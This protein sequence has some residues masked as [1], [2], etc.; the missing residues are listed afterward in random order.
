[1]REQSNNYDSSLTDDTITIQI[2]DTINR[3]VLGFKRYGLSMLLVLLSTTLT[4]VLLWTYSH[5]PVYEKQTIYTVTITG[6]TAQDNLAT[7]F[8]TG[9]FPEL[10]NSQLSDV[11]R[12]DL[13]LSDQDS[14][15]V[16]VEILNSVNMIRMYARSTDPEIAENVLNVLTARYPEF[17]SKDLG[18][19]TLTEIED[20]QHLNLVEDN[21]RFL[22]FALVG[23]IVGIVLNSLFLLRFI[24]R[25]KT[26]QST[27]SISRITNLKNYAVLPK[28]TQG[29]VERKKNY[30][31]QIILQDIFDQ[32]IKASTLKLKIQKDDTL[33]FVSAKPKEGVTTIVGEIAKHLTNIGQRPLI[34]QIVEDSSNKNMI[35]QIL[36]RPA[37]LDTFITKEDRI[38]Y[39]TVNLN[40][41]EEVCRESITGKNDIHEL[42]NFLKK[43]SDCILIDACS[44]EKTNYLPPFAQAVDKTI[45]IVKQGTTEITEVQNGLSVLENNGYKLLGYMMN[46]ADRD[47][48]YYGA[49]GKGKYDKYYTS[50][51][52]KTIENLPEL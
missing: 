13:Q 18:N 52:D 33:M 44:L 50:I 38:N 12:E 51:Q 3:L 7:A 37:V 6:G 22:L 46:Y 45:Y 28:L 14:F 8:L 31:E 10:M 42:I 35:K 30:R 21:E 1:M 2:R 41:F 36:K 23:F 17:A 25:F 15:E 29:K 47:S 39:L 43:R 49:Y 40:E 24:F 27:S 32:E 4:A 9:S 20:S 16:N 34:F 48:L 11:I 26:V 19:V 5:Q